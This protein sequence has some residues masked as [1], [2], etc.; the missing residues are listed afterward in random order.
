MTFRQKIKITG[1]SNKII[2]DSGLTSTS[3][4]KKRLLS[5]DVLLNGQADNDL[6]G[7]HEKAMVFEIPDRLM[8]VENDTWTTNLAKP[9]ARIN[10]IEV[11]LDI[12][13]GETFK[14]AMKCGATVKDAYGTYNY[15]LIAS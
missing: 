4:E 1:V 2:Y 13:V 7:Y 8:D 10:N 5:I 12:P 3:A 14:L 9:G 11:G 15:E 6:Q